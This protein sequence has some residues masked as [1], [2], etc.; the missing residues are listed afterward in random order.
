[1]S[2]FFYVEWILPSKFASKKDDADCE[3]CGDD[4]GV[5]LGDVDG[6]SDADGDS[7]PDT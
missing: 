5:C 3:S 6:G 2:H 1:M 7:F 4:A